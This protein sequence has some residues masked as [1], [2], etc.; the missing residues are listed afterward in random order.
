MMSC[1]S[2]LITIR[3]WIYFNSNWMYCSLLSFLFL[4]RSMSILTLCDERCISDWLTDW[5]PN[6]LSKTHL[7]CLLCN[8]VAFPTDSDQHQR[9]TTWTRMNHECLDV[10]HLSG[11]SSLRER[12]STSCPYSLHVPKSRGIDNNRPRDRSRVVYSGHCTKGII[13]QYRVQA[14]DSSGELWCAKLLFYSLNCVRL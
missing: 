12:S 14:S 9:Q 4:F 3:S 8:I 11:V 6:A 5:L 13:V 10:H 1:G 2:G 7:A